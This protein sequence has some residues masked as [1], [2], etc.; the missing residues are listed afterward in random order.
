MTFNYEK[1][2]AKVKDNAYGEA[3]LKLHSSRLNDLA[4]EAGQKTLLEIIDLFAAQKNQEAWAKFLNRDS[5]W[6]TLGQAAAQDVVDSA[7]LANAWFEFGQF[8]RE[9]GTLAI[10]TLLTIM[11]AGFRG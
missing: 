11:V 10:K 2:L 1:A 9:T 3:F 4:A 8:L 7:A 6:E 5:S